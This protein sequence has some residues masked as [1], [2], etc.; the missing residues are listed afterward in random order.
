MSG[1]N[2]AG[3][4]T[5]DCDLEVKTEGEEEGVFFGY[6]SVFGNKDSDRD[7]VKKGAFHKSLKKRNPALLWQHDLKQPIG[8]FD[9]VREDDKGLYVKGRL[10]MQGK[11]LE[12]YEL[13][14]MGA[15][16]GL[17]IGFKTRQAEFE[18]KTNTRT[19]LEADLYEI[20]VVTVPANERAVI[21]SVKSAEDVKT[22]PDL[23][24][25]LMQDEGLTPE[26]AKAV[27]SKFISKADVDAENER[28][29]IAEIKRALKARA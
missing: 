17:S 24:E 1:I 2:K 23:E 27:A 22:T 13:L 4:A 21:A 19:I 5:F 15:L 12:A 20:S 25:L 14:K 8:R 7:I 18:R 29:A 9:E 6:G 11:G 16:N 10:M 26:D 3:T 28:R